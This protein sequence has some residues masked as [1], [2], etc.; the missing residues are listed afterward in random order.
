MKKKLSLFLS[1]AALIGIIALP[2]V[3][4]E[5]KRPGNAGNKQPD[6][7][8]AVTKRGKRDDNT[9]K[10]APENNEAPPPENAPFTPPEK[11]SASSV[12]PFERDLLSGTALNSQKIQHLV[13]SE[14]FSIELDQFSNQTARDDAAYELSVL[15]KKMIEDQLMENKIQ[16]QIDK[17]VCGVSLCIGSLRGGDDSEYSRWSDIFF[18]DQKTP[19]YG[20]VNTTSNIGP[21]TFEH[22]FV[23]STDPAAN[24][25][26]APRK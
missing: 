16:V 7:R 18:S 26:S 19:N 10:E 15:Y 21:G 24:S 25:I 22:R 5:Y 11:S 4:P 2:I 23:F 9:P 14:K 3:F 12:L 17:L 13:L 20:F 1:I 6:E 8:L